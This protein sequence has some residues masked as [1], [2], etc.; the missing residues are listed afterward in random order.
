[1]SSSR[2]A[3]LCFVLVSAMAPLP[4]Q[5]QGN[6]G[7]SNLSARVAALEAAVSKL[8]GNITA[9]DLEGTYNFYFVATA[10]YGGSTNQITSYFITGTMTF[11]AGGTGQ[12]EDSVAAGGQLT[13]QLPTESWLFGNVGGSGVFD[14][15]F[16]WVYNNGVVTINA[17][18]DINDFTPTVGGQVMVGVQGG[19]PGDNQAIFVLTRQ[20]SN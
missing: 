10:L 13:E 11:E 1:M 4:A 12:V 16:S 9:A 8:N 20:P 19:P 3:T 7:A 6:S 2:I 15:S 14:G 17:G 5:A 18:G